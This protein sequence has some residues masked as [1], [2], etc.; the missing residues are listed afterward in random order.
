MMTKPPFFHF[1]YLGFSIAHNQSN[2]QWEVM[3]FAQGARRCAEE[4]LRRPVHLVHG[5]WSHIKVCQW[6]EELMRPYAKP[7]PQEP[8]VQFME[9][10]S[11]EQ[12]GELIELSRKVIHNVYMEKEQWIPIGHM[13]NELRAQCPVGAWLPFRSWLCI[14]HN[15]A[16]HW[17]SRAKKDKV[18]VLAEET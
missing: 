10:L 14:S 12:K 13:L 17:M 6:L 15:R 1:E 3:A 2:L 18:S 16:N 8:V 7:D 5:S 11:T 9:Q 4:N